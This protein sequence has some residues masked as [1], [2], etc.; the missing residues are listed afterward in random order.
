MTFEQLGLWTPVPPAPYKWFISGASTSSGPTFI[1]STGVVSTNTEPRYESGYQ[2]R[3]ASGEFCVR[4]PDYLIGVD[5]T[6]ECDVTTKGEP[7][8]TLMTSSVETLRDFLG[9]PENLGLLH[10]LRKALT[11]V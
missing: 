11:D 1:I 2:I 8:N 3:T 5:F 9:Q 6:F 7:A 4:E 10:L